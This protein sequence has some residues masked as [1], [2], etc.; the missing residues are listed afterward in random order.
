MRAPAV[1]MSVVTRAK[2]AAARVAG[3]TLLQLTALDQETFSNVELL[4]PPGIVAL[5][6]ADADPLLLQVNGTRNHKVALGGDSTADAVK[7]LQPGE[8]GM[9]RR[10]GQRV[11][12]RAGW[13]EVID[14]AEIRLV[15]P[16][17]LWSP[18]GGETFY[19]L[20]TDVHTH[21]VDGSV[22]LAPNAAAGMV[23]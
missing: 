7:D 16:V 23:T 19:R 1:L 8:G 5:P 21:P 9:A 3:R 22:T 6:L 20:T 13:T 14:P 12:Q 10:T 18:D 17:L 4:M 2:V 15:A 11:L